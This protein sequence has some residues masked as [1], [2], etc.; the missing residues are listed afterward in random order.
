MGYEITI[1]F[2]SVQA[3]TYCKISLSHNCPSLSS[4][5]FRQGSIDRSIY[6]SILLIDGIDNERLI[7]LY[8]CCLSLFIILQNYS[9]LLLTLLLSLLPSVYLSVS[10][11]FF[12]FF[13]NYLSIYIGHSYFSLSLSLSLSI[14]IYIYIYNQWMCFLLLFFT[15]W[16]AILIL[17]AILTR[18]RMA[19]A[20]ND[21]WRLTCR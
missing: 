21:P 16:T 3:F 11:C 13:S 9:P 5:H 20:L 4:V 14:Y 2:S 10:R 15:L 18:L 8:K 6:L 19:F 17:V 1:F 7:S 12:F